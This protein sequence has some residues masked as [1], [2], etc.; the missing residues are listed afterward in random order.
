MS[1][2][3]LFIMGVL[4]MYATGTWEIFGEIL[5]K[6]KSYGDLDLKNVNVDDLRKSAAE[7]ERKGIIQ[8]KHGGYSLTDIGD[9]YARE[10]PDS[11]GASGFIDRHRNI[12]TA[13]LITALF[14]W[15]FFYPAISSHC[16]SF[17]PG[18]FTCGLPLIILPLFVMSF[19]VYIGRGQRIAQEISALFGL[20][21]RHQDRN[22]LSE[23]AYMNA[24]YVR[25]ASTISAGPILMICTLIGLMW[26]LDVFQQGFRLN[27]QLYGISLGAIGSYLLA[28]NEF[29]HGSRMP[30]SRGRDLKSTHNSDKARSFLDGAVGFVLL[31]VG[32]FLQFAAAFPIE[33][34][35]DIL[36][37]L[38]S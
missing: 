26:A 25:L 13:A 36:I 33:S 9:E 6:E 31:A 17:F 7:L 22:F 10:Y 20:S 28:K 5:D 15:V 38:L 4:R 2:E 35:R 1:D 34:T 18:I 23:E 8:Y 37:Y 29:R 3:H 12:F 32:F 27:N 21:I 11:P 19:M 16:L 30:L 14:G 24:T